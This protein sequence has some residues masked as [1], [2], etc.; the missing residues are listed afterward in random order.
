MYYKYLE[1]H[2]TVNLK[3]PGINKKAKALWSLRSQ[4]VGDKFRVEPKC[5]RHCGKHT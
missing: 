1:L 2:K 4:V 3:K 5:G